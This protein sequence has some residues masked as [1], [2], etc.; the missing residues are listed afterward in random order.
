MV[1][2]VNSVPSIRV[3]WDD[4]LSTPTQ[5][6]NC[7]CCR[8]LQTSNCFIYSV[9]WWTEW[10]S[11][12]LQHGGSHHYSWR[13][14]HWYL[15]Q[16]PS[17]FS[18]V[19]AWSSYVATVPVWIIYMGSHAHWSP[20]FKCSTHWDILTCDHLVQTQCCIRCHSTNVRQVDGKYCVASFWKIVVLNNWVI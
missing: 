19:H 3:H 6:A 1:S 18:D 12:K 11:V 14:Q 2:C 16:W 10:M 4:Q 7:K 8:H 17:S 13:L 5:R 9:D 15:W 20:L